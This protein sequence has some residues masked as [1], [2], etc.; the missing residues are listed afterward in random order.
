MTYKLS[1][2][3]LADRLMVHISN[4]NTFKSIYN[5]PYHSTI[6]CGIILGVIHPTVGISTLK[7]KIIRI[8]AVAQLRTSWPSLFNN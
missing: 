7:R 2:A 5:P 3:C 8:I 1:G 6:K 4:N